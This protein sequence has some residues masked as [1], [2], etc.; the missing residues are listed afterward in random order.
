MK[1]INR[2]VQNEETDYDEA[3]EMMSETSGA[4]RNEQSVIFNNNR[5]HV[6]G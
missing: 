3:G 6:D 4:H 1:L 5:E 2:L